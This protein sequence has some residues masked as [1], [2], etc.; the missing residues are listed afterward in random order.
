MEEIVAPVEFGGAV[1]QYIERVNVGDFIPPCSFLSLTANHAAHVCYDSF[2]E[3]VLLGPLHLDN[4]ELSICVSAVD[5]ENDF[6]LLGGNP[7]LL[8]RKHGDVGDSADIVGDT[9]VQKID[10]E[11][12]VFLGGEDPL[13]AEIGQRVEKYHIFF[14]SLK[15]L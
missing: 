5:V 6:F 15:C 2:G 8:V 1:V 11:I 12:L 13:E 3:E 10:E 14:H 9:G 7:G 4:E